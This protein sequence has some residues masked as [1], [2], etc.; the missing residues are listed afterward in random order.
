[1][2]QNPLNVSREC[3]P[4]AGLERPVLPFRTTK[5]ISSFFE[6]IFTI[7]EQLA[8]AESIERWF[9]FCVLGNQHKAKQL[10]L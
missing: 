4:S 3:V 6:E 7:G 1:M 8:S 10:A 9:C 2:R 5:Q